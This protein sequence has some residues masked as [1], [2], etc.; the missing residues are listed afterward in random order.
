MRISAGS[1]RAEPEKPYSGRFVVRGAP[2]LHQ[3]AAV[4]AKRRGLSLNR[5]IE[6]SVEDALSMA[7]A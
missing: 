4:E 1:N 2:S 5:F 3:R 7:R 6:Q